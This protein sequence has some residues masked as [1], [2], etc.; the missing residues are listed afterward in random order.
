MGVVDVGDSEKSEEL[1]KNEISKEEA[2]DSFTRKI[3]R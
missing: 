2:T 1:L 3:T